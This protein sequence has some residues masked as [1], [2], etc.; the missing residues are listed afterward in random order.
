MLATCFYLVY[1][2]A[3]VLLIRALI[4]WIEGHNSV[5]R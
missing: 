1:L 4:N 2:L 3:I 5:S